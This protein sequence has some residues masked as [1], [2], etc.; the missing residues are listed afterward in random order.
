MGEKWRSL[1]SEQ[2][3]VYKK[4]AE[5]MKECPLETLT[6]KQKRD[7][8]GKAAPVRCVFVLWVD[9]K[10]PFMIIYSLPGKYSR[11]IR[12]SLCLYACNSGN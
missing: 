7:E 8:D 9:N 12:V 1:P 11:G 3:D 10:S 2:K 6:C 4:K 5:E